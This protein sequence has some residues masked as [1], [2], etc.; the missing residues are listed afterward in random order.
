MAIDGILIHH[1]VNE[2][3]DKLVNGRINKI[4]QPNQNDIVFQIH[5]YKTYN[6]LV[7]ISFNYPRVYLIN[8][9][10]QAPQNP[11]NLCMVLRKYLE[12]GIIKELSQIENDRI[13]ILKIENKNEMGDTV[14]YNLII[15]LMGRTSNLILTYPN[16]QI[17]EVMRRHF[18]QDLGTSR[19]MIPKATYQFPIS[20]TNINPFLNQNI[21][22]DDINNLQGVSKQHKNEILELG[23][24][25]NFIHQPIN[26]TIIMTE[27]KNFFSPYSL[28][29]IH[30]S[31][32]SYASISEMLETYFKENTKQENPDFKNLQKVIT[33]KLN[34]LFNKIS[35]LE[36]DLEN[37][38]KH[39]NDLELGQ[40]LQTYLYHIKKGMKEIELTS[41]DGNNTYIISLDPLKTPIE[42]MQKYFKSYKKSQNAQIHL[43]KQIEITNN[44]ITYLKTIQSQL[45]FVN[46]QE[47]DEIK[48][49]LIENGYLKENKNKKK[50]KNSSL[51]NILTYNTPFGNIYVGKNNL[52]NNFLTN[53][54]AKKDDYWF[55]VKDQPSAHV[56]LSTDKLCEE[57]IR[58]CAHL[59]SLNSKYEKSSSVCVDYTQVRNIKKVPGIPGCFVTYTNQRSIYIDPSYDDLNILLN[60]QSK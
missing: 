48:S 59:A 39:L 42:N 3:K 15:E 17:I 30:G 5:N 25:K 26:P 33:Q 24:I 37:S 57:N 27:T 50:A 14:I 19:I 35:N 8:E 43:K 56:I 44:E 28:I 58:I 36:Q 55:H 34:I 12:R 40:L 52:Q 1:L 11:F 51:K 41:F 6:L 32:K 45:N 38:K 31:K 23:S 54:F 53:K 13:I 2:L 21:V 9:K 4:I 7:S 20:N 16:N 46:N 47:M 60:H 10:P 29:S 22:L 18:P 49:E